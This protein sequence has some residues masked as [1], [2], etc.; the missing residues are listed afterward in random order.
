MQ[1]MRTP[2]HLATLTGHPGATAFLLRHGADAGA[3]DDHGMTALHKAVTQGFENV[4]RELLNLG[5]DANRPLPVSAIPKCW[6]A[7]PC[8]LHVAQLIPDPHTH[9]AK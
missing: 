2:L 8:N 4:V 1:K 9:W 7:V 6:T 3:Q 5:A